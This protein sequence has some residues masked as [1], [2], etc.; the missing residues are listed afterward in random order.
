MTCQEIS[1]LARYHLHPIIVILN[2]NGYTTERGLNQDIRNANTISFF[3]YSKLIELIGTG[4][5]IGNIKT[6]KDLDLAL[7]HCFDMA[8]I[9]DSTTATTDT[10][11]TTTT[12]TTTSSNSDT[13][14]SGNIENKVKKDGST[15]IDQIY[16]KEKKCLLPSSKYWIPSMKGK[17]K[18]KGK[19]LTSTEAKKEEDN[20]TTRGKKRKEDRKKEEEEN[21]N[22]NKNE[23]ENEN[24]Y[25]KDSEEEEEGEEEAGK[26]SY[27][28]LKS[29]YLTIIEI[30]LEEMGISYGTQRFISLSQKKR[31]D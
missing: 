12:T 27:L 5:Y 10:T 24:D 23:N 20:S 25:W 16:C 30:K 31:K 8:S 7:R 2:N 28:K 18:S 21:V 6:E 29:N 14:D 1:A 4:R 13:E 19:G 15:I 11:T 3:D 22:K 17:G 26:P 9:F